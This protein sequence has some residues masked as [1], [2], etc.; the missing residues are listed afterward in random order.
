[1]VNCCFVRLHN[2]LPLL[3][4]KC[5]DSFL[6]KYNSAKFFTDFNEARSRCQTS[7]R[8]KIKKCILNCVIIYNSKKSI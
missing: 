1:M 4:S 7:T 5:K 2:A 8:R 6:D 3:I